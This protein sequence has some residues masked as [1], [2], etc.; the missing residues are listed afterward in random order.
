MIYALDTNAFIAMSNFYE[1]SFPTFWNNFNKLVQDDNVISTAEN[2]LEYNRDDFV[3]KWI[4]NNNKIFLPPTEEEGAF[5][6]KIYATKNFKDNL[7]KKKLTS[8]LP[9][10]DP[11]LIAQAKH[12]NATF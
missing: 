10:A 7:E 3:K 8:D 4:E 12:K 11:F 5:I 9:H 2:L 1:D 6:Q